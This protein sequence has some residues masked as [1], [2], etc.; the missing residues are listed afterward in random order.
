MG[1]GGS[2]SSS[3]ITSAMASPLRAFAADTLPHS[4]IH[5]RISQHSTQARNRIRLIMASST[6]E[7]Y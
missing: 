4:S 7:M 2:G 6:A 3:V 5:T 1:T